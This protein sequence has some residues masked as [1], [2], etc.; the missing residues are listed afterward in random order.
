MTEAVLEPVRLA[1][2]RVPAFLIDTV[3]L[4][5][6]LDRTRTC[7]VATLAIRPN[8]ESGLDGPLLAGS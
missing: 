3:H 7:I 8:P 4:D 2:Y 6:R 5:I 1:D